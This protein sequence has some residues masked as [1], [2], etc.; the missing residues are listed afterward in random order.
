MKVMLTGAGGF[1]GTEI[2]RQLSG[3]PAVRVVAFSSKAKLPAE[4]LFAGNLS[5]YPSCQIEDETLFRDA[6]VLINCAFPRNADGAG[7]ARG[8]AYL[9]KV[10]RACASSGVALINISSQSVYDQRRCAPAVENDPLCLGDSYAVAKYASELLAESF[11]AP[12]GQRAQAEWRSA[13]GALG[14]DSND[15]TGGA[16]CGAANAGARAGGAASGVCGAYTNIRL[17][18]L[19]GPGFDQRV[20]NKLVKKALAGSKITI[21][22]DGS[23]Y[24]YLDVRD[25]ARGIVLIAKSDPNAWQRVY[26]LGVEQ[27]VSLTEMGKTVEAF[28]EDELS[29]AVEVAYETK[30]ADKPPMR[31]TL[32]AKAFCRHFGWEQHYSLKDTTQEIFFWELQ[33]AAQQD[34]GEGATGLPCKCK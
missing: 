20:V 10:F 12:Q 29:R 4:E 18:S 28:M 17:A 27:G 22:D 19:I 7:M 23:S 13:A 24:G 33:R 32:D 11:Y 1:L 3:E 6:D 26:N 30:T 14:C 16:A 21:T 15:C 31:T 2:L 9:S 25:A 34:A 8:M 5:V